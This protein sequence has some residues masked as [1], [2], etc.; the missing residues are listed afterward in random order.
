M[1]SV[2]KI[3]V[4]FKGLFNIWPKIMTLLV[5]KFWGEK[6][7]FQHPFSAILRL[8]KVG[9]GGGV[10]FF[11][12][13]GGG[14]A[15]MAWPLVESFFCG[16]PKQ[17]PLKRLYVIKIVFLS[18]NIFHIAFFFFGANFEGVAIARSQ[19]RTEGD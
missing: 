14:K 2:G 18:H 15:L 6:K 1:L 4:F 17:S 19:L 16:F 7:S 8:K 10:F 5:Q 9:W 13:F 11:F 3:V 12:F